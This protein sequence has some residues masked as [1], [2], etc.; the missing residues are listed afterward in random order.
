MTKRPSAFR[1]DAT[2]PY[3]VQDPDARLD[4]WIGWADWLA[5][6]TLETAVFVSD[7]EAL[8][9]TDGGANVTGLDLDGVW[10]PPGTAAR[11]FVEGAARTDPYVVTCSVVSVGGLRD[12]RSFR[13]FI[14]ER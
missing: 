12:E 8:T 1:Y 3:V 10:H 11:V 4:Y 9:T 6:D 13:V 5:G 7:D 2:G 14:R